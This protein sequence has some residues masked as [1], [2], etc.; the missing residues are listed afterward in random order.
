MAVLSQLVFYKMHAP[1]NMLQL[2]TSI[3]ERVRSRFAFKRHNARKEHVC[4]QCKYRGLTP[5]MTIEENKY[6][7]NFDD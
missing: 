2:T 3:A 7:G 1:C 6:D 5:N 4:E